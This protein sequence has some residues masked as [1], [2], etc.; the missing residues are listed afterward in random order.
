MFCATSSDL[1]TNLLYLYRYI[2]IFALLPKVT[3]VMSLV[4]V[5]AVS[6]VTLSVR[7]RFKVPMPLFFP[8]ILPYDS[9]FLFHQIIVY[10][11]C[12]ITITW[13]MLI[14]AIV[15]KCRCACRWRSTLL[16]FVRHPNYKQ[17][18]LIFPYSYFIHDTVEPS[19]TCGLR[20]PGKLLIVIFN[21]T[22]C[23]TITV[24]FQST[25]LLFMFRGLVLSLSKS[26]IVTVET[27]TFRSF[28]SFLPDMWV[29]TA[30]RRSW[31]SLSV[32]TCAA[33]HNQSNCCRCISN[34]L[35]VNDRNSSVVNHRFRLMRFRI[36]NLA[37]TSVGTDR[38]TCYSEW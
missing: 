15:P 3:A 28:L 27:I 4:D 21:F 12:G 11:L 8:F 17:R 34:R 1:E 10:D 23:D 2:K 25:G 38:V 7:V 29:M 16:A 9:R 26:C 33:K 19:V 24:S 32:M 31:I 6:I 30:D 35:L 18:E 5:I 22:F 14:N 36:T 37:W 20:N 13:F